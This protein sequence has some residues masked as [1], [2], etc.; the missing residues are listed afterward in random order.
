MRIYFLSER[1]AALKLDGAYLGL[2]D[3]FEKFVDVDPNAKILVEVL[4]DGNALP[5]SFFIDRKFFE[6]PPEFADV[7]LCGED[8]VIYIARYESRICRLKVIAQKQFCG[9]LVTL[10]INGGRVYLNCEKQECSLYELS[11]GFENAR[12]TPSRIGGFD[13]LLI[14]GSGC[15]AVIS[16]ECKRVFYNP[17]ESW[18][19]GDKLTIKVNFNTCAGCRAT[20]SFTYDGKTMTL[21]SSV[22]EESVPPKESVLHFAFFESVMCKG[23]FEKYLSES[24]KPS[25]GKLGGFLGDFCDVTIP[26]RKFFE[27]HGDLNAAGLVYPITKNLFKVKYFAVNIKNS[28]ID[29]IYQI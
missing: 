19:C 14:E 22:T 29:N 7:Y 3:G 2:I 12:L 28:K 6:N 17:A 24:L 5:I 18:Q 26:Y 11:D 15:L 4:P 27:T 8:A 13:V 10:F 9:G 1:P 20:C 23:D 21:E 16:E 25:A